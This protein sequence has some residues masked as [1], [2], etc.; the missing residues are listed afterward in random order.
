MDAGS[1]CH[2]QIQHQIEEQEKHVR[3]AGTNISRDDDFHD[4]D[5]ISISAL[6]QQIAEIDEFLSTARTELNQEMARRKKRPEGLARQKRRARPQ[7]ARPSLRPEHGRRW[8]CSCR[9]AAVAPE[10]DQRV[11]QAASGEPG[12]KSRGW[13]SAG[14][15]YE[16]FRSFSQF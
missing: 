5:D 9:E 13:R 15:S 4:A 1:Q 6:Q 11:E 2:D 7:S 14:R 3:Q 12:T 16:C 8:R 10:D